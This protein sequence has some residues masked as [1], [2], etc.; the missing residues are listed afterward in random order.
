MLYKILTRMNKKIIVLFLLYLIQFMAISCTDDP[1]CEC[2]TSNTFER[3]FKGLVLTEWDTSGFEK[4]EVNGPVKKNSFAITLYVEADLNG[5][6][7]YSKKSNV[8]SFGFA[9]AY[10]CS[11]PPDIFID[12]DPIDSIEI[13]VINTDNQEEAIVTNNFVTDNDGFEESITISEVIGRPEFLQGRVFG[14]KDYANIPNSSIFKVR[15]FLKSGIE[16]STQTDM[17][18]FE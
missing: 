9:S 10:A 13:V 4:S 1:S 17:I 15:V 2:V 8:S 3:Q 16:L 5:I 7:N 11:C 6:A 14:L 12:L 18:N